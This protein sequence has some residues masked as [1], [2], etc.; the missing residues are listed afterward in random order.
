MSTAHRFWKL[1]LVAT[2]TSLFACNPE[3]SPGEPQTARQAVV[4]GDL[5]EPASPLPPVNCMPGHNC[6]HGA[7]PVWSRLADQP[8]NGACGDV[9]RICD[10]F[11]APG[12]KAT[13][14]LPQNSVFSPSR[15][16]CRVMQQPT[17][18]AGSTA[19]A[20]TLP[21][22]V[23]A[24]ASDC[25]AVHPMSEL[26]DATTTPSLRQVTASHLQR[27]F[28]DRV[29]KAQKFYTSIRRDPRKVRL[30][31]VDAAPTADT[32]YSAADPSVPIQ[33]P[34]YLRGITPHGEA[35][36][37]MA[38]RLV[39]DNDGCLVH[40]TSRQAL[41]Y[42]AFDPTDLSKSKVDGNGGNVGTIGDLAVAIAEELV[43]W[44]RDQPRARLVINL[45]LGWDG[46]SF[47]G[48]DLSPQRRAGWSPAV[49]AVHEVLE[50]ASCMGALVVAAAGNRPDLMGKQPPLLPAAWE[51]E[52]APNATRCQALVSPGHRAPASIL[53]VRRPLVVAAGGVDR[54]GNPLSNALDHGMPRLA[55][56]ADHAVVQR[57]TVVPTTP[58]APV[59]DGAPA[60]A[61][62]TIPVTGSSAAAMVISS[63]AAALWSQNSTRTGHQVID[64]LYAS[65]EN[66]KYST[67]FCLD[68]PCPTVHRV[69]IDRVLKSDG[70]YFTAKLHPLATVLRD[71]FGTPRV[72]CTF[73]G[74]TTESTA[75][76]CQRVSTTSANGFCRAP[77]LYPG[78]SRDP[79]VKPQPEL[80][81]V[82]PFVIARHRFTGDSD[83]LSRIRLDIYLER[84]VQVL[85]E[86][87]L[88][89]PRLLV[90]SEVG[91]WMVPLSGE[92][93]ISPESWDQ[94]QNPY[95]EHSF[96]MVSFVIEGV[97]PE[98]LLAVDLDLEVT[99][100]EE[101]GGS[102]SVMSPA[103][104]VFE[105]GPF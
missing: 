12:W 42:T 91:E 47:S 55:A 103:L 1:C 58:S 48:A 18:P 80:P 99:G 65:G 75:K 69:S 50:A 74:L 101:S 62:R 77:S 35:M 40:L 32:R 27:A 37:N 63:T 84:D 44:K 15:A 23:G 6:S 9:Q 53:S 97:T 24:L 8:C 34:D 86:F 46:E 21:P 87:T 5:C 105:E 30:A 71:T 16:Y 17:S 61:G 100:S 67:D 70:T 66:I 102:F 57:S 41:R 68:P 83:L 89:N 29:G 28:Y 38:R 59:G 76:K 98:Q 25:M 64:A 20:S 39:C 10:T 7:C 78:L 82:P 94:F 14:L 95:N 43:A 52:P 60:A 93:G 73:E 72:H 31:V 92:V 56:F 45:S 54:F 96:E 81:P 79:W 88:N 104:L 36:T 13:P 51:Q 49:K 19:A 11:A 4:S 22:R 26:H 33:G 90:L 2:A 85:R 3:V